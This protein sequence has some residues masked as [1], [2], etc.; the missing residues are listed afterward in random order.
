MYVHS[1]PGFELDRTATRSSY[2]YGRQLAKSVKV[3]W[4]EPTMVEAERML[5]AA[6]LE[7]PTNQRFVLLSDSCVPL[8]NFSYIYTYLMASPKSFV[9]SFIDKAGKRYNPNMSPSIPKDKWRKGSQWV[10]LIRKHAEVVVGDKHVFQV[11]RKHCKM[12]VTKTLLGRKA[13]AR[14]LGFELRRKQILKGAARKEH[15]CIPDEH[16]VQTLFSIKGLELELERRT[17][18][19]TSW[20]QSSSDPKDKNTWH[21]MTFEYDTASPEHVNAIKSIDH[22]NYQMEYRTEW[23]QCNGTSVPCFLFARKFSYSASMHLLEDGALG[24]LKYAQLPV[25]F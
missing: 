24:P 23:C 7:D 15:D 22:V 11:F 4:G 9:D 21:P 14:R 6:A 3:A 19:Y 8:Y 5:F 18:T 12:V 17:L 1:A 13:N 10:M 2:F 25:H 20:N 16:Y